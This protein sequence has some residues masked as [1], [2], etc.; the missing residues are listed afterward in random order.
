MASYGH[1][2]I[3]KLRH[4]LSR[5]LYGKVIDD[6]Q[7]QRNGLFGLRCLL[8]NETNKGSK[9]AA[10]SLIFISVMRYRAVEFRT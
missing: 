5:L 8:G 3:P 9:V 1:C 4:E 10:S 2:L 6:F 7:H